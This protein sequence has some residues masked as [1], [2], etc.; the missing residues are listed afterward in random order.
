MSHR[1]KLFKRASVS[2]RNPIGTCLLMCSSI[3]KMSRFNTKKKKIDEQKSRY[4]WY[5]ELRSLIRSFVILFHSTN[6][7]KEFKKCLDWKF[8][9]KRTFIELV[10]PFFYPFWSLSNLTNDSQKKSKFFYKEL[11]SSVQDGLQDHNLVY[12]IGECSE[13]CFP[14]AIWLKIT[15]KPTTKKLD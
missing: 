14:Q 10:E 12:S 13:Q 11:I 1:E 3:A 4:L 5:F 8:R 7:R 15:F 2:W 9:V 6:K